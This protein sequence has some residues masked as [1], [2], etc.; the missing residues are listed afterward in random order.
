MTFQI[1]R[2]LDL[3]AIGHPR[4]SRENFYLSMQIGVE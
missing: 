1:V 3:K 4:N 2:Y